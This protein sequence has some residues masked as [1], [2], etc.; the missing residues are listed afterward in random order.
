[1]KGTG[2]SS[3]TIQRNL[4]EGT[5]YATRLSKKEA[6]ILA[7]KK[8]GEQKTKGM[9]KADDRLAVK[10]LNK[11]VEKLNRVNK[12]DDKG[13]KFKVVKTPAG[14]FTTELSYLAQTYRDALNKTK[15]QGSLEDLK[16]EFNKFK[17]TDL[18]KNYS[19][20]AV[21]QEGGVKSAK[22]H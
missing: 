3:L 10:E 1:M 4:K 7:G 13:I 19:K 9:I 2:S 8:S 21:M 18:F 11:K 6:A 15:S 14:N 12:L 17:K 20:T 16:T 22:T 5:D